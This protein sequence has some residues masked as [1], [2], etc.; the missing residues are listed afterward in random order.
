MLIAVPGSIFADSPGNDSKNG[1]E[2]I[3]DDR[4]EGDL[5]GDM[6]QYDWYVIEVP[7]N[8]DLSIT[9]TLIGS[10]SEIVLKA[11]LVDGKPVNTIDMELS[12]DNTMETDR[13]VN[14]AGEFVDLYLVFGGEGIYEVE[15]L[16]ESNSL[17]GCCLVTFV[18]PFLPLIVIFTAAKLMRRPSIT[19]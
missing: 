2:R 18:L 8:S 15:L 16:Y 1:A 5:S 14:G 12:N 11:Q 19:K 17:S 6:D 4:F 7:P 9:V 13:F 10:E 3:E